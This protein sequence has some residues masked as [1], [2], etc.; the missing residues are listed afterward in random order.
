MPLV[1]K[2]SSRL[3]VIL[4]TLVEGRKFLGGLIHLRGI[5]EVRLDAFHPNN[6][7]LQLVIMSSNDRWIFMRVFILY[8]RRARHSLPFVYKCISQFP[9]LRLKK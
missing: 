3:E 8:T 4:I 1:D 5:Y 6:G 7:G 9:N 2:I